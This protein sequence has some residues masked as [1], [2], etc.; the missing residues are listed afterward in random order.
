MYVSER[1]SCSVS[2]HLS[3]I[4][5]PCL[6]GRVSLL[7]LFPRFS[8]ASF[9][10]LVVISI[11][12][13]NWMSMSTSILCPISSSYSSLFCRFLVRRL[14]FGSASWLVLLMIV[15]VFVRSPLSLFVVVS[16]RSLCCPRCSARTLGETSLSL[17]GATSI[18][19]CL[20]CCSLRHSEWERD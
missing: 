3:Q 7:C 17:A 13:E 15:C 6:P 8:L 11:S 16:P 18:K 2:H 10:F 4:V 14:F 5:S 1:V 20:T 19:S 9:L 12:I